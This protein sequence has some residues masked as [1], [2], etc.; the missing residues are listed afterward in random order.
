LTTESGQW[1][2]EAILE[3]VTSGVAGCWVDRMPP[4][5]KQTIDTLDG[6]IDE[7]KP[8]NQSAFRRI[9]IEELGDSAPKRETMNRHFRRECSC[10][11]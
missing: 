3:A 6:Y 8:F 7:D 9:L 1:D 11:R 5:I 4:H 2:E 10:A